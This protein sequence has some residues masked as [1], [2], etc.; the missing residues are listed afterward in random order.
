MDYVRVR[1]LR[2]QAREELLSAQAFTSIL[3]NSLFS[4]E[5]LLRAYGLDP[6]VCYLGVDTALFVDRA[7]PREGFVVGV[8]SFTKEKRIDF[9]IRALAHLPR[10]QR[11]LVWIGNMAR[12]TYLDELTALASA[13]D[14]TFEPRVALPDGDIVD[15]LSRAAL[16]A[17]APR[18]EPFGLAPLE[19]NACGLP[20]VA[21]AEGG[22]RETVLHGENGLLCEAEPE[23]MAGAIASLLDDPAHCRHLGEQA[24][25]LV[26]KRWS[27]DAAVTRLEDRL[28][29]SLA[30]H[31]KSGRGTRPL[32]P[33][34]AN[35]DGYTPVMK[36]VR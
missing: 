32:L 18:L 31:H 27:V 9:V 2:I 3:V 15:I 4:R 30:T 25:L 36:E 14:V 13:L 10:S 20:V 12:P 28:V 35:P 7:L 22:V 11:R 6:K 5:S 34:A 21:V 17:Y 23:A 16:M 26:R 1:T 33:V 29:E 8:G 19:A 24:R